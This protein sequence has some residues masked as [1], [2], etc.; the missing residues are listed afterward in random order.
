MTERTPSVDPPEIDPAL[1]GFYATGVEDTRLLQAPLELE[2]NKAIL[3]ERLPPSGRII[4]VGGGTGTYSA[5][6]AESGY[7]VDLVEPIPLHLEQARQVASQGAHFHTHLGEARNL[8]FPDGIADAVLL[9]GPLYC[10]LESDERYQALR[11]ALRVLRPGGV[12]AAAALGRLMPFLRFVAQNRASGA[13]DAVMS[14]I[15]T[16][17]MWSNPVTLY[18]HRPEQLRTEISSVG[19]SEVVVLGITG[20]Y[21]R[22][23]DVPERLADPE[24]KKVLLDAMSRVESDPG[25]VGISGKLMAIARRPFSP[26]DP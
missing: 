7:Q 4:D 9:M 13:V 12:L 16:G 8:D 21:L 25:I 14:E 1:A 5:W 2:R 3:A 24:S 26:N 11:E 20:S 6:L 19:F 15:E 22:V 23:T 18:T 17:R 10:L